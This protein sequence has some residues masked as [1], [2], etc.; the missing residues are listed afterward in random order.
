MNEG[1]GFAL[2]QKWSGRI[3]MVFLVAGLVALA[4]ALAGGWRG[5]NAPIALI[6]GSR[7]AISGPLPPQTKSIEEFIIEGQPEDGVVRL[8]PENIFSGY[9][10]GGSMWRGVIAVAPHAPQKSFV[11]SIQSPQGY[12]QN[13][14]LVFSVRVWPDQS[15]LNANSP[16]LL[17]RWTG[18]NPFLL[19]AG[20]VLCGLLGG[21]FNYMFGRLW[22]RH[23]QT[24]H[25][26]EIYKLHHTDHGT[27]V[28]VELRCTSDLSP[29]MAGKIY[30]P[31]GLPL[32]MAEVVS[33]RGSEVV[34][35][36]SSP[37]SAHLGDIACVF[38]D[39]GP[40]PVNEDT[41]HT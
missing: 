39:P 9:L 6:P 12:K 21:T 25:C 19:A 33:C 14:A 27:E 15:T 16:S 1:F 32:C 38:V 4:D 13:P 35:I 23:L 26:G 34:L 36:V 22:A 11:I 41:S 37:G 20:L 8:L 18:K 31:A 40:A 7:Y 17:T 24:H 29:G 5:A 30:S 28:T 3:A 10:F 2:W